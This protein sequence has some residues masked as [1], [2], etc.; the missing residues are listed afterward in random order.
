MHVLLC[1]YL[2]F[3]GA[4]ATKESMRKS[5]QKAKLRLTGTHW[6][7]LSHICVEF[8]RE[9][10]TVDPSKRLTAK[11]ALVHKWQQP[12]DKK[13]N[14]PASPKKT[15]LS[16][17]ARFRQQ[18]KFKKAAQHLVSAFLTTNKLDRLVSCL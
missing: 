4:D 9:L 15:I 6:A 16:S 5:I 1:G 8:V 18:N 10:L 17:L 13:D 14:I 11:E 12:T 2:P 7:D 3:L